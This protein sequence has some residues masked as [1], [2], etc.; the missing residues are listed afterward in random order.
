VPG[1]YSCI[2]HPWTVTHLDLLKRFTGDT[3]SNEQLARPASVPPFFATTQVG[4]DNTA[5]TSTLIV[6]APAQVPVV[7]RRDVTIEVDRSQEFS[8][9]AVLVRGKLRACSFFPYSQAI[10]KIEN[11]PAPDPSE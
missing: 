11:V 9:D 2:A 6:F 10:V 5:D 7:R 3:E 4:R 1:P 8:S